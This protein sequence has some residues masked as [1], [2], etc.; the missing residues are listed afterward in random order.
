MTSGK[1]RARRWHVCPVPEHNL[2]ELCAKARAQI[3]G[4]SKA[5]FQFVAYFI[6]TYIHRGQKAIETSLQTERL[7]NKHCTQCTAH[8]Q[9]LQNLTYCFPSP[10]WR[11]LSMKSKTLP[12]CI[13]SSHNRETRIP[14]QKQ[15]LWNPSC[16]E[17]VLILRTQKEISVVT[18]H[19]TT[20]TLH[21][22][23]YYPN[24]FILGYM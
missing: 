20:K 9:V 5:C 17:L 12:C 3:F 19:L 14:L 4:S 8:V 18:V 10:T 2:T 23:L 11:N 1:R 22:L 21:L 7:N 6:Y 13:L 24:L 16:G 15:G